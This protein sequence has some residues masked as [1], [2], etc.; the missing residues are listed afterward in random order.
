MCI[1][2]LTYSGNV[3]TDAQHGCILNIKLPKNYIGH[4]VLQR[5]SKSDYSDFLI[6]MILFST[7]KKHIPLDAC[8]NTLKP[9]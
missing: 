1:Y 9:M 2:K 5:G 7:S 4:K 8:F 3:Y 6:E